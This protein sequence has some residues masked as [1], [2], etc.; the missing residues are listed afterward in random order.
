MGKLN[1]NRRDFL[2]LSAKFAALAAIAGSIGTFAASCATQVKAKLFHANY[3]GPF[4]PTVVDGVLTK[5]DGILELDDEPNEMLTTGVLEKT[6]AKTRVMYPLVRKSYLENYGKGDVRVDLRGKEPFVRVDWDTALNLVKGCIDDTI[7]DLGNEGI[8]TTYDGWSE[9]HTFY[10]RSLQARFFAFIGGNTITEG[11][12]STGAVDV[13]LPY[14]IGE[15][16]IY[17]DQTTWEVLKENT[18]LFV[19]IGCDMIKNL[20]IDEAVPDHK[21]YKYWDELK[22]SGIQFLSIDPQ[23]TPTAERLDAETVRVIPNTDVA[24]FLAMSYHLVKNNLHDTAYLEKYTVGSDKFIQY[25]MGED[26]DGTPPKTAEWASKI[27]GI[28]PEKIVELA[29]LMASKKTQLAGSW[30]LQRA[31][32]GEL[33]HWV[34]INFACLL[35]KFGKPGEGVGFNWHYSSAGMPQA[36]KTMPGWMTWIDNP[37]DSFIP[38]SRISDALNNP[39]KEIFYDGEATTYPKLNLLYTTSSNLFSHHQDFNELAQ[40]LKKV[41]T[42]I[43]QDPMFTITAQQADIVLPVT[44]TLERNDIHYGTKYSRDKIYAMKKIIEPVGESLD[45]Y[46]I[47]R[48]LSALYGVDEQFTDGKTD[49]DWIREA[50]AESSGPEIATFEE[51]WEKGYITFPIPEGARK[52][53]LHGDFYEDPDKNPL[54]TDSG[55]VEMYSEKIA[56]YQIEDCPPTPKYL[57]PFEFLGNAKD[58]QVHVV[59]PHP[60][61]RLHSQLGNCEELHKTYAVQGREP[62]LIN[63]KDAE[64]NG[65][66]DGDVVELYNDRGAVLAGAIVTDKIREGV[67]SLQSGSWS[68][69][70]SKGRCNSG[71]INFITSSQPTSGLTQACAANTCVTYIRKCEDVEGPNRM[72]EAPNIIGQPS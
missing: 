31:S 27:T 10:P 60:W 43:V 70:D 67:V 62:V 66:A 50:Y 68:S 13:L 33:T 69:R 54:G 2:G 41:E 18:E 30:S 71:Q 56:N 11:N 1:L 48:R 19:M 57:E 45:D 58:G 16:A 6:Y 51:F 8:L 34:L 23:V 52:F 47:F 15:G 22:E 36:W 49:M 72:F 20:R 5:V 44:T 65:I 17:R 37:I 63:P 35:G 46:E 53:V 24:L 4:N 61:N 64:K 59:S 14:V 29:E 39:G 55:K 28:S 9:G 25:V 32:H 7:K 26:E 21:M 40:A 42:I 38:A 12:Y 3:W